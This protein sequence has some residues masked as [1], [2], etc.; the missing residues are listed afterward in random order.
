MNAVLFMIDLS[1][2]QR[3]IS[4]NVYEIHNQ[5]K[6]FEEMCNCKWFKNLVKIILFNKHD[7]FVE[8]IK[9]TPL[10]VSFPEY[11]GSMYFSIKNNNSL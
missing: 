3:K 11:N 9:K 6:L 4:E 7:L 2:Y 8:M 10:Q 1:T 5:L